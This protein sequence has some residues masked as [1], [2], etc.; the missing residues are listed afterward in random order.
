MT[1]PLKTI[2]LIAAVTIFAGCGSSPGLSG[3]KYSDGTGTVHLEFTDGS[4]ASMTGGG[5]GETLPLTYK[6]SGDK[7]T[8]TGTD[9]S[10]D[11][12]I[13]P[14]GT[15]TDGQNAVFTKETK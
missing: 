9:G 5:V 3:S 1:K 11:L 7:I 14:N 6:V 10:H 12:T 4:H 15:L 8:L 13:L 2:L